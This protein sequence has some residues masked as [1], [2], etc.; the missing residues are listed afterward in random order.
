MDGA[1]EVRKCKRC[2]RAAVTLVSSWQHTMWGASTGTSTRDYRCQACGARF[3]IH[4]GTKQLGLWIAGVLLLPAL[5]GV[6]PLVMAWRRS[7]VDRDNPIVPDAPAPQ[8]RYRDG[9]PLRTCGKCGG[10]AA[11]AKITRRSHNG[12]PSGIEYEYVCSQ[13]KKEFV[14]ESLWGQTLAAIISSLVAGGGL[15]VLMTV[16]SPLSR[17]GWGIGLSLVG[18]LLFAQMAGRVRNR[19][20]NPPKPDLLL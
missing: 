17:Y 5:V 1:I 4:P 13:C 15:L 8:I 2:G 6:V 12:L 18:L 16:E 7:R 9:P 14:V 19:F 3:T 11:A 10:T 20:A